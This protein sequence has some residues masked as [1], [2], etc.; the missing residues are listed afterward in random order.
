MAI[1]VNNEPHSAPASPTLGERR[2]PS[3]SSTISGVGLT[4]KD[5]YS[6]FE[7]YSVGSSGS[8]QSIKRYLNILKERDEWIILITSQLFHYWIL[9]SF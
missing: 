6:D 2:R 5:G 1:E 9:Q 7:S 4:N 3:A 8:S